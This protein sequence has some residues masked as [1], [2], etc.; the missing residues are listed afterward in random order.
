M[1]RQNGLLKELNKFFDDLKYTIYMV[2]SLSKEQKAI[3]AQIKEIYNFISD[4]KKFVTLIPEVRTNISGALDTAQKVEEVAGFDGRITVVNGFPKACGEAK[5]GAS[6]HTAR[7]IL[8]AKKFDN[9]INFVMNLKY[10][11]RIIDSL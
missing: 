5:F 6:N 3:I 1:K 2:P 11:P 7:L 9:S 8:T 10:I 4:K